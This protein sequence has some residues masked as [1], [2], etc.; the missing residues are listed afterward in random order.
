VPW[1]TGR[2]S[3]WPLTCWTRAIE[4]H[5][6][7]AD[8]PG[9]RA[10]LAVVPYYVRPSEEAI[11]A[12]FQAVAA[13]SPVPLI[14]YNIPYRTGRGLGAAALLELA[15]TDGIAALKQAVGALDADTLAVLAGA[16]DRFAVL[17]GDDAFLFPTMLIGG[18]GAIA[19]AAHVATDRF[20]A[21][22]ADGAAGR[23]AEGRAHAE[24]LLPL[25]NA[26]F[27]EP[28]PAVVKG[29]LHAAGRIA[30]PDVRMPL[31]PASPAALARAQLALS[32]VASSASPST[33]QR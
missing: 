27:T 16:P 19:A 31:S 24:T 13:R 28:N 8:V 7:L 5:A 10:S 29:L 15:A 2:W 22:L 14:I 33:L 32:A 4:R 20:V 23:V 21:M 18:A 11:V 6:A 9:I 25:V 26:V 12:H 1:T 30:T 3:S 17:G